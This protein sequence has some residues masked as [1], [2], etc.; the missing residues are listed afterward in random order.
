MFSFNAPFAGS[1]G[2][3]A[4]NAP[5]VGMADDPATGGYWEV[6]SDGGMFSFNA[7]FAGSMGGKA[8]NAPVVGMSFSPSGPPTAAGGGTV[9]TGNPPA[10]S[11]VSPKTG[12]GAGGTSVTVTGTNLSGASAV[13]FGAAAAIFSVKS[14]TTITATSPPGSGTVNVTVTTPGGTSASVAADLFSYATG[15]SIQG[16]Y[17]GDLGRTGYA[18]GETSLNPANAGNLRVHWVNSPGGGSFAQPI[19][20]NNLVYWSDWSGREHG[21]DLNGHDVWTVDLGTTTPPASDNCQPASAGPTSTPT[22]STLGSTPVMYVGGGDGVF[23]ALNA[24]TGA[25]IWQTRLGASP[26]NFIWDSP[27]L[28]NGSL[29]IGVSSF[30]DCPL[31]QGKVLALNASNGAIQ[32]TFNTVP[33]GC[34][35]GG[36]WGSPTVDTSDGSV[37]VAT[38][39]PGCGGSG[40]F[41]PSIVKLNASSLTLV[42]HWTVPGAEQTGDSDFGSTPTL[43]SATIGGRSVALVGL[44]DKN[45]IFY[46]FDR[47]NIAA[48][49]RWQA[50]ITSGGGNGDPA[51]GSIVS[52]AWDGSR[53]YVGG[54]NTI[55]NGTS[56]T[57]SID[58]LNP[59]NGSFV[60]Q[61]CQSSHILGGISA[62]PGV[63][64]EG[65]DGGNV[66]FLNSTNGSPLFSYHA[67]APVEG[68]CTVSNGIVYVSVADGSL[69]ALGQ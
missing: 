52:A 50:K 43:F 17:R 15:Q 45:G 9:P 46:A 39:N 2:G 6:A 48:G 51:V 11:A 40:A 31:V 65:T 24:L 49:P 20:A 41:A 42:S 26:D 13:H 69:V 63:V 53:L 35:G 1:M 68:S 29:Y 23:Y 19:V 54:G 14:A 33:N 32:R 58:A 8:L 38:G 44:V 27:A 18:A 22:L 36:V 59:A 67:S 28:Y 57:A 21:T 5:V 55:V 60:W 61:S 3:K 47:S 7:P 12:P 25:Q 34:V 64:I 37:Y 10:V 66:V 16:T 4:L 30:G 62:V 56:C